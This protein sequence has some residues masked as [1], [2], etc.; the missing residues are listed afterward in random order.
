MQALGYILI[1]RPDFMLQKDILNLIEASLSSN[2]DYRM[3]V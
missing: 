1:A 2:V 3:K